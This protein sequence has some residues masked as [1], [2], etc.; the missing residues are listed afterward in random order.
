M[1]RYDDIARLYNKLFSVEQQI[2]KTNDTRTLNK[3]YTRLDSIH[4]MLDQAE[5]NIVQIKRSMI[6][7]KQVLFI[8]KQVLFINKQNTQ[9][10]YCVFFYT[11]FEKE[12]S[13]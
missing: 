10:E 13:T 11:K 5:G 2:D 3:L 8:N 9:Y 7:T 4:S 6:G 1:Y 12:V